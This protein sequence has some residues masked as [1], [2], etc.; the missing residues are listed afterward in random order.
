MAPTS[1]KVAD[2]TYASQGQPVPARLYQPAES[3]ATVPGV[4][5]CPGRLREIAG[6]A[7]LCDALVG[8][9][10]V[11]LATTYR[12][13]DLRTD[14]QDCIDGLSYLADLPTVD[15]RRL[16]MIGHSRGAMASLRVAARDTR[17]CSVVALMP[18]VDLVRAVRPLREYAPTRYQALIGGLGT[19]EEAPEVYGALSALNYADRI[20]VPVLLVAGAQDLHAPPDHSVWMRDALVAAGHNEVRLEV[21]EGVGHFFERMYS[22]YLFD[23]VAGLAADWLERT[24]A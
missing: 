7:F 18:P 3:E 5:L 23:T 21:L 14:D 17:V 15:P 2:I 24:L 4:L 1:A 22:G 9:G 19:P 13:M 12:G 16:G 6:L 20:R 11:V 8:R 10:L